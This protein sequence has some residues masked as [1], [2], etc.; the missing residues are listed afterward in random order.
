MPASTSSSLIQAPGPSASR[1][2]TYAKWLYPDRPEIRALLLK[3]VHADAI[4]VLIGRRIHFSTFKVF[5]RCGLIIHQTYN[6]L[7]PTADRE[8]A[9]RVR[10]KDLLG[11]HDIRVG[12]QPDN[13]LL[14]F[15]HTNLPNLLDSARASFN[16]YNDLLTKYAT[17]QME[18]PEFSA[19]TRRRAND[20]P[21]D[22]DFDDLT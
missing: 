3:S 8:L 15:I 18:Y 12:N 14:S 13:R 17:G 22:S 2:R 10:A 6:Q 4:P 7:F 1:R 9:E 5:H 11:Y 20:L 16:D 19:R 21:E